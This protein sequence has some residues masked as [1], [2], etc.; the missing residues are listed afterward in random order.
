MPATA[1]RQQLT[2][3]DHGSKIFKTA[4]P[5]PAAH[6]LCYLTPRSEPTILLAI[7]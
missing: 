5:P 4:L 2:K 3:A 6:I 1:A 7:G